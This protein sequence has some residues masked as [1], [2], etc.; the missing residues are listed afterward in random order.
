M[1]YL[2]AR[3]VIKSLGT[4]KA[5]SRTEVLAWA[6][7]LERVTGIEPAL[8]AWELAPIT[9]VQHLTCRFLEP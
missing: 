6:F 8:S 4:T 7:T 2:M 9:P 5:Q 1:A 3:Q